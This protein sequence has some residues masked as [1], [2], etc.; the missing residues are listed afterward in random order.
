MIKMTIFSTIF[1]TV[2]FQ[3]S[4]EPLNEYDASGLPADVAARVAELEEHGERFESAIR[5]ILAAAERPAWAFDDC[6]HDTAYVGAIAP[7]S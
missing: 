7:Q 6:E 1:A 5:A 3:V 4:G 2:A